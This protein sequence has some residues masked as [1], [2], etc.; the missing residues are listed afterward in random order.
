MIEGDA[1]GDKLESIDYEVKFEVVSTGGSICRM[2][3]KYNSRGEDCVEEEEI[4][5]GKEKAK[6]IYKIVET[7]LLENPNAYS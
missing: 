1:L 5:A 3:S 7:Y 2:R 6:A 4:K